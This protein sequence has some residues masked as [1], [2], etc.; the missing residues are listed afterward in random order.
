MVK[1]TDLALELTARTLV[2]IVEAVNKAIGGGSG[3][4]RA[5]AARRMPSGDIV[6]TFSSNTD[7]IT[8]DTKWV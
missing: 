7:T 2:K 5:V 4:G 6:L 8:K 3:S 1:A